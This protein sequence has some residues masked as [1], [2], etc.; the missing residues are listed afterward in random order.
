M[1]TDD[2]DAWDEASRDVEIAWAAGLFEG[3]GC[4]TISAGHPRVKL[5]STDEDTVRRFHDAVCVG[6]VRVDD[7]QLA[8]GHKRQWEW[9][10]GSRKGVETVVHLLWP[11]LGHRRRERA[12]QL[13]EV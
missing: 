12:L 7:S 3:E 8:R 11:W 2:P 9:Y 5:N 4:F 1:Q 6:Q 13:L 10:T